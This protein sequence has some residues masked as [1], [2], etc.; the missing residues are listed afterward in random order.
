MCLIFFSR[1]GQV[2]LA[3]A[4]VLF[5]I[6]SIARGAPAVS[7]LLAF[8]PDEEPAALSRK[9]EVFICFVVIFS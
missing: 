2:R 8:S 3:A 6:A 1:Y 5:R 4:G 9:R 7:D